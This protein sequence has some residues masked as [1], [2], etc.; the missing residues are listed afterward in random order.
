MDL[1]NF[2]HDDDWLGE[3]GVR[4]GDIKLLFK[5]FKNIYL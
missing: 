2:D 5:P 3:G 1:L 4:N